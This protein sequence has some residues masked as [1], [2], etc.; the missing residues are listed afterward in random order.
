MRKLK[1]FLT[2]LSVI[3]VSLTSDEVTAQV[4]RSAMR[5]YEKALDAYAVRDFSLT[6]TELDKA[7]NKSP[8]YA[9]AWFLLAQTHRDLS[10]DSIAI[11]ELKRA[12]NIDDSLYKGGWLELAELCW[13]SGDY[14]SGITALEMVV[15]KHR[16]LKQYKWVKAGLEFSLKAVK[17]PLSR[18]I[19]KPLEGD[20]NS[21]RPEYFPTM[22]L[23]GKKIVF[24]RLVKSQ[25]NP[26]GQ[27]E[28]FSSSFIDDAWREVGPLKGIN[29][30][31]N[32]GAC[33]ISGDGKTLIFTSCATPR[34]GFGDRVGAGSCDLFESYYN[35]QSG[36]WSLGENIGA[37]NSNSWESQPT[38]SSDGNF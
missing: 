28:F 24:T 7:V 17:T 26:T 16:E 11:V 10:Q 19:I 21:I 12:L 8:D 32:E 35:P 1:L 9:L 30:L 29:T 27:E 6:L 25:N 5:S 33:S 3:V 38:Q 13:I 34:D 15:K 23:S 4:S 36:Y 18:C 14:D 31:F 22:E 37:P 2:V 20:V